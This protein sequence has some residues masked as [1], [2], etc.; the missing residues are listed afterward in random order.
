[1]VGDFPLGIDSRSNDFTMYVHGGASS[2]DDFQ[3]L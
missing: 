2:K 3:A 1:M